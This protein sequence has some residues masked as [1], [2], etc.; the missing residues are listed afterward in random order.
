MK[1]KVDE[2]EKVQEFLNFMNLLGKGELTPNDEG[3]IELPDDMARSNFESESEMEDAIID[4][5]YGDKN[6]HVN[7]VQYLVNNVLLCQL[8]TNISSINKKL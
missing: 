2:V 7:D 5:V 3:N 4:Y 8:N 1:E 6:E